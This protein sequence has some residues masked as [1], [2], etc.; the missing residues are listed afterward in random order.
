VGIALLAVGAALTQSPSEPTA[1]PGSAGTTPQFGFFVSDQDPASIVALGQSL[2]VTPDGMTGYTSGNSWSSIASY[3][4]PQTSLRLFLSV[5]MNP[6][7]SDPT[8]APANLGTFVTLA[9]H[10]VAGGQADAIIR[11]GWEW[12]YNSWAWANSGPQAYVVAFDDE[13]T[14]MRSVA[15]QHFTFD[16]CA[17]AGDAPTSG[18]YSDWYPDGTYS[19]DPTKSF[20]DIIGT[21]HYDVASSTSPAAATANWN[22]NLNQIGGL[23]YTVNFAHAHGKQVSVPE[24]GLNGVDDPTFIDLMS[25]FVHDP[26]NSVAYSSYFSYAGS[27]NSD[28][29]Q[30]P[31]SAGQVGKD[32]GPSVTP[33]T[34]ATTPS[35]SPTTNP[36][37][38]APPTTTTT[39]PPG[40]PTPHVMIVMMENKNFS[41]VV[42]QSDQPFTNG[43]AHT[44][45]MASQSFALGHP[46]LPN[47]LG[48]VSGSSQGVTDD[49]PPSSHSFAGAITLADQLAAAGV[50]EKAYAENL[51]A[52][53]SNSSGEYAV[54]HFPWVYFPGTTMPVAD[55]SNLL[56]D[57]NSNTPPAFVWYTP[58]LIDDE[59][60]GT[61]QQGDTFLATFIPSVESTAWFR[62]GGQIVL[63]WD[64]ADTDN[65]G[66]NSGDGGH[67]PTIVVSGA[68]EAAPRQDATPVDSVGILHSI[69]DVYG[70]THL[71]GSSADGTIDSLLTS[72]TPPPQ[73][74]TTT[75]TV[76]ATT[77]PTPPPPTTTEPTTTT[78]TTTPQPTTTSPPTTT[79]VPTTT[80]PATTTT[81][82][83]V[84]TQVPTQL[85]VSPMV[86]NSSGDFTLHAVLT[87][88]GAA[89]VG[90]P[91][92]FAVP[93]KELCYAIT[94]AAGSVTCTVDA[95]TIEQLNV[96]TTGFSASFGGTAT[97]LP[98]TQASPVPGAPSDG[99]SP[100]PP[101]NAASNSPPPTGTPPSSDPSTAE[102]R[103][104]PPLAE[105]SSVTYG[106]NGNVIVL[107]AVV[108]AL[109]TC[110]G[111]AFRRR[112]PAA[113]P[114]CKTSANEPTG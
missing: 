39:T 51:P 26:A 106:D 27:I 52:D 86:Q 56:S 18:S 37:T 35:T 66:I 46:S 88:S 23:A 20:V 2:G 25:A 107:I 103:T 101:T 31:S 50:S 74:P 110:C 113:R 63:E 30:F 42:G 76:P 92:W 65:S 79:T 95:Q 68:L 43:L 7:N 10:L 28:I 45:G 85:A 16:W 17:N 14:A 72:A 38:T 83:P 104:T 69:E 1:N 49:N 100:T 8:Q 105:A 5:D 60:D 36:P 48:I 62:D 91:V 55:S 78:P 112:L 47:Y 4:P 44:F 84:V 13:V 3:T 93:G 98:T 111:I 90:V 54:W 15:G 59:H 57:L 75:T 114:P 94:D 12:N 11:I 24:W 67:V 81:P 109:L 19:I 32:F 96:E 58:N 108:G 87:A 77:V 53:P 33:T 73:P 21:D 99:E 9:Q 89:V 40:N 97:Y 6:D 64:E 22:N 29:T 71:G 80:V 34:T 82:P 70:V 61:V 102:G 41:E